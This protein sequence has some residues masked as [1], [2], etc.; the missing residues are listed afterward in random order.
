MI[1]GRKP[2]SR[3]KENSNVLL[4]DQLIESDLL[5]WLDML[6]YY[7]LNPERNL[8]KSIGRREEES[9][10]SR[11][12]TESLKIHSVI[13]KGIVYSRTR[14]EAE[15][16]VR[17]YHLMLSVF[18]SKSFSN[19]KKLPT[20]RGSVYNILILLIRHVEELLSMIENSFSVYLS[21][22]E[23]VPC[24]YFQL[25]QKELSA[26][27]KKLRQKISASDPQK[28]AFEIVLKKMN[29]FL[30]TSEFEC[31]TSYRKIVYKK[32]LISKIE[33]MDTVQT[34]SGGFTLLDATLICMNFNSLEYINYLVRYIEKKLELAKSIEEKEKELIFLYKS[35]KQLTKCNDIAYNN[36][37]QS[38]EKILN[39]WFNSELSYLKYFKSI[40]QYEK[41][42]YSEKDYAAHQPKENPKVI[43]TL[44]SDQIGIILRAAADQKVIVAKS[45]SEVFKI[46]IPYISTSAKETLSHDGVRSKAYAAEE[47][48]KRFA[49]AALEQ[50]I[51]RIREY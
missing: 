42:A 18:L 4:S 7:I 38:V 8:N 11:V 45:I 12:K 22:D 15:L 31:T 39:N 30:N 5:E 47:R 36:N 41:K 35:F 14:E 28:V 50:V 16:L 44:S 21:M 48:D 26:R 20:K 34:Q 19:V 29:R 46:A 6:V 51:S 13:Q 27:I 49:I 37:F 10:C 33:K 40:N 23:Y 2:E 9:I 43:C 17:N 24:T 1:N 25:V 3:K 32:K